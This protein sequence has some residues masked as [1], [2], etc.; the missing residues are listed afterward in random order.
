[1]RDSPRGLR[2][3]LFRHSQLYVALKSLSEQPGLLPLRRKLGLGEPWR[4]RVL[5]EEFGIYKLTAPNDLASAIAATDEALGVIVE[6]AAK[7]DF[8]LLAMLIPS[9]IQ[10]DQDRWQA[11]LASLGLDPRDY[12]PAVPT[13][14]FEQLLAQHEIPTLDLT[15]MLATKLAAGER[16]YFKFDRH[17]T[18]AGHAAAAEALSRAL[19]PELEL[20]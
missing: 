19:A 7:D 17:W 2:A 18:V 5:R 14:I 9:E 16:L 12:D 4:V 20:E 8:H 10:L 3:W 15:P 6:L 1:P 13:R 11:G